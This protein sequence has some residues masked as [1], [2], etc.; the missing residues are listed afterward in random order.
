MRR[1]PRQLAP[2]YQDLSVVAWNDSQPTPHQD[3]N[4]EHPGNLRVFDEEPGK[5]VGFLDPILVASMRH[6]FTCLRNDFDGISI[7]QELRA[8]AITFSPSCTPVTAI[9]LSFVAPN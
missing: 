9:E 2:E 7:F 3:T 6:R 5:I 4:Q 8:D 1:R